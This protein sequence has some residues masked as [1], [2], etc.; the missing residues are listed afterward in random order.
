MKG[1]AMT[2]DKPLHVK[3]AIAL[4]CEPKWSE[5]YKAY[6]CVCKD[7]THAA[8]D[9]YAWDGWYSVIRYDLDWSATGPLV[10][11][12][13]IKLC[14]GMAILP[15]MK[16]IQNLEPIPHPKVWWAETNFDEWGDPFPHWED[17][18]VAA[19]AL[20][21]ICNLIVKLGQEGKL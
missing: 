4:G 8:Q 6:N 2:D 3:M 14:N 20:E 18:V 16:Q 21:A 10:E 11:K 9:E 17:R 12:Y 7:Y 5:V 13:K 1:L 15:T 19:T